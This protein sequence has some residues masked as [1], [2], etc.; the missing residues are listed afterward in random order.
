MANHK[1]AV[2]LVNKERRMGTDLPLPVPPFQPIILEGTIY[3]IS[4]SI[5]LR[6]IVSDYIDHGFA[7]IP[8][9]YESKQ[10]VNKGWT[11]L[12]IS[13][14]D[15]G[16]YF[17]DQPINIGVLTGQA[18]N[19]LVDIDIDDTDALRFG[20]WFLPETKCVFGRSSK[21]MS[22]WVYRVQ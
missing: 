20:R 18:S 14:G 11:E 10:P 6:E 7:P 5:Y 15:I 8:I 13:K 1:I 9:Q 22:H 21:P 2:A 4:N 3:M 12:R 19:G 16:T 17:N